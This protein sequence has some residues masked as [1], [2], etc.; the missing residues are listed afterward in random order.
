MGN[1][2]FDKNFFD[3]VRKAQAKGEP[4]A[5]YIK[6]IT[7]KVAI[8]IIDPFDGRPTD[9]IL[10]GDPADPEVDEEDIIIEL[11]TDFEHEYFRRANK[12]QL[13]RGYIAPFTKEIKEE[14]SVN[15]I[16]DE[17][18]RDVLGKP[19]FAWK[20]QLDEFTSPIPVKRM[21]K[22]AEEMN[23]PIK[24]INTIKERLS[25]MQRTNGDS[26]TN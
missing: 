5:T 12:L 6:P 16:T 2:D 11:W 4:V 1:T 7:A 15:E 17:E 19:Y 3:T 14:I 20:N 22:I 26:R 24:T 13:D 9:I 8:S 10:K 21:L 18:L 25:N 23:R